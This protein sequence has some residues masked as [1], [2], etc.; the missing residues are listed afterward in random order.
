MSNVKAMAALLGTLLFAGC[1]VAEVR[2]TVTELEFEATKIVCAKKKPF[3]CTTTPAC[4][5]IDVEDSE[6]VEHEFCIDESE[7]KKYKVGDMYPAK[8]NW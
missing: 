2:G 8:Q 5:E 7:W 1:S 4:W 6:G 3:K